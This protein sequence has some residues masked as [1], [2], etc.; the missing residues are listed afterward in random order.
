MWLVSW[1]IINN[2]SC[3]GYNIVG[4]A[5]TAG[6]HHHNLQFLNTSS[7]RQNGRHFADDIFKRIFLNKKM[8]FY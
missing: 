6:Y 8:I 3:P 4:T 1:R 2:D 7:P 5:D